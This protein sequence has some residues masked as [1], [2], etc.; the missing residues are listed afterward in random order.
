MSC[1]GLGNVLAGVR[2]WSGN[3][4][5][6]WQPCQAK[7]KGICL[8]FKKNCNQSCLS[9]VSLNLIILGLG[10]TRRRSRFFSS[11]AEAT[12]ECQEILGLGVETRTIRE[13]LRERVPRIEARVQVTLAWVQTSSAMAFAESSTAAARKAL[14]ADVNGASPDYEL[15]WCIVTDPPRLALYP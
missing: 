10:H 15:P 1:F 9:I 8:S 5:L 4:K 12:A 14:K 6:R 3:R 2:I 7:L 11:T 13:P